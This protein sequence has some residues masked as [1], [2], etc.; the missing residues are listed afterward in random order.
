MI[1]FATKAIFIYEVSFSF[2]YWNVIF[3]CAWQILGI[4]FSCLHK[5]SGLLD[6]NLDVMKKI[7]LL[8]F[9]ALITISRRNIYPWPKKVTFTLTITKMIFIANS[10]CSL[11]SN[12]F[13]VINMISTFVKSRRKLHLKVSFVTH[14]TYRL[15]WLVWL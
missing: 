4:I 1:Y 15:E 11:N 6:E 5:R 8:L 9:F 14:C 3:K 7:R 13:H 12:H 2:C 10:D